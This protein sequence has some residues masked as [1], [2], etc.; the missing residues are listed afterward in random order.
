M[1][2]DIQIPSSKCSSKGLSSNIHA[3]TNIKLHIRIYKLK[4]HEIIYRFSTWILTAVNYYHKALHL[5]C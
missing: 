4:T 5:G 1:K 2:T 3:Y